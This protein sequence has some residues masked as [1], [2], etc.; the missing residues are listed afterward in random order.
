MD[1]II[2]ALF[3]TLFLNT[4][5]TAGPIS[6]YF[7]KVPLAEAHVISGAA[8]ESDF[9]ADSI[10]VLIWNIKKTQEKP[11]Q[12]EFLSLSQ[13]KELFLLQ[14]AYPNELF[15]STLG[16][17]PDFRWDMGISFRYRMY[18]NLPTGTMIGS[19]VQ[20]SELIIKHST[21]HE[22]GTDTPKAMTFGKYP[23]R[24]T[25]ES[26][27]VIN[28]HG[29][30]FTTFGSF[31]RNMGQAEVEIVKHKGPILMAGDFNTRTKSRMKFLFDLMEK[32]NLSEVKFKN[33][34][35]RMVAKFTNN[36]LDHG[37]VRGLNVKD[38]EVFGSARG[39]DHKP[40]A[41]EISYRK[42]N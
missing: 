8:S 14:E 29:I 13:D 15:K 42:E 26:L 11:W 2:F 10:K 3:L 4:E 25:G 21:D 27:L 38:A 1:R 39:S 23:L 20:P 28:V 17:F 6:H 30:N 34:H 37:F 31:K 18:D 7:K 33:G 16:T 41:L 35:Q 24:A 22:P 19:K 12:K 32:H 9:E 5:V 40:M 36:I